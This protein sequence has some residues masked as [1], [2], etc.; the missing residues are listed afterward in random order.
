[1][2]TLL[3]L[4]QDQLTGHSLIAQMPDSLN[5]LARAYD[6]PFDPPRTVGDVLGLYLDGK[7]REIRGLGRRRISEIQ[8]ALVLAGL[9]VT[10]PAGS[11]VHPVAG[12]SRAVAVPRT[13]STG[14]NPGG[15]R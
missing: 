8:A 15:G 3:E 1:M 14:V 4:T 13:G 10:R 2:R 12:E 9:D 7:L 6:A 5:P 11:P